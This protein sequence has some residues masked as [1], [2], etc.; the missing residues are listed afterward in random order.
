MKRLDAQR[1][2]KRVEQSRLE[3]LVLSNAAQIVDH[4]TRIT[5]LEGAP[6]GSLADGDYGDVTVSGSGA[7]L[8]VDDLAS[9]DARITALE[10]AGGGGGDILAL[11]GF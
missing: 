9:H 8:T 11:T 3:S 5:T 7:V 4:E 1:D 6:S 10:G 2:Y